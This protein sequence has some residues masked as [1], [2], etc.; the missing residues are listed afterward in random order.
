MLCFA[1]ILST[2]NVTDKSNTCKSG[3]SVSIQSSRRI[4][5]IS[6]KN[7]TRKITLKTWWGRI[8]KLFQ[9]A[10]ALL[11]EVSAWRHLLLQLLAHVLQLGFTRDVLRRDLISSHLLQRTSRSRPFCVGLGMAPLQSFS[12]W[13][14]PMLAGFRNNPLGLVLNRKAPSLG[15]TNAPLAAGYQSDLALL[16]GIR[17][18]VMQDLSG[19]QQTWNKI[20]HMVKKYLDSTATKGTEGFNELTKDI[21]EW[22]IIP[23]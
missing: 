5:I 17:Q 4:V 6:T 14:V 7:I 9:L 19:L 16:S 12:I 15:A 18:S 2:P 23:H 22:E 20:L 1:L 8:Q 21:C 13:S 3:S 11:R 10:N